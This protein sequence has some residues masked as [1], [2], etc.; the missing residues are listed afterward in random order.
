MSKE[1]A[2]EKFSPTH[3]LLNVG[4]YEIIPLKQLNFEQI[5]R[6]QF[7]SEGKIDTFCTKCGKDSVFDN[8]DELPNISSPGDP[9]PLIARKARSSRRIVGA[10]TVFIDGKPKTPQ[11]Y[12]TSPR[13]FV[14]NLMC[15]REHTHR[16]MFVCSIDDKGLQK[17]GQYP[18][19]AD[20]HTAQLKEYKGVLSQDQSR[21]LSK[22]VGLFAHGIGIGSFVY[23]RRVFEQLIESARQKAST[24]KGWDDAAY[25]KSRMDEKI[26]ILKDRLPQFLVENRAVYGILSKGIHE[27]SEKECLTYFP[28]VKDA[29]DHILEEQLEKKKREERQT[30][31]RNAVAKI[32][33]DLNQ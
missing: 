13:T 30:A 14:V 26:L 11:D 24:D 4:L 6:V 33:G 2:K 28:V 15:A 3:F 10:N 12:A 23:L 20:L 19:I 8:C 9:Q 17:I 7:F 27:L 29:I 22:G 25:A 21:E 5:L 16:M 32:K 18:S 1:P 31:T